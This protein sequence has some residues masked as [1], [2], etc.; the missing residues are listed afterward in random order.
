V[1]VLAGSASEPSLHL[2]SE[3]SAPTLSAPSQSKSKRQKVT[4]VRKLQ[5]PQAVQDDEDE[6]FS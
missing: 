5:R 4:K 6:L 2:I 3:A 1:D